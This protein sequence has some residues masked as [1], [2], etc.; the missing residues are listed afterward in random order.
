MK[1]TKEDVELFNPRGNLLIENKRP[2]LEE[3]VYCFND[4]HCVL[5]CVLKTKFSCRHGI[6]RNERIISN[7]EPKND[8]D[9]KS[10]VLAY[11]IGTNM[12][13][14]EFICKTIDPVLANYGE[15]NKMCRGGDIKINYNDHFPTQEECKCDSKIEVP[16]TQ[17]KR[18]HVECSPK[19]KS[20][21][22]L[23]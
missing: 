20:F 17:Q 5:K 9:P 21:W 15:E 12:G 8:C 4:D 18:P 22:D 19:Y 10:G 23:K 11:M 2:C 3:N 1:E 16:G 14:Y 6:C 13:T 7:E